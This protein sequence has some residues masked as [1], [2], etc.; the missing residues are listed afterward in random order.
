[1]ENLLTVKQIADKLAIKQSTVYQWT[2]MGFM[3]YVRIGKCIRFDEKA[4]EKWLDG[5]KIKGRIHYK[6][7][8]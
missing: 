4:I 6:L 5:R 2:H 3:P 8:V 1:M 7:R